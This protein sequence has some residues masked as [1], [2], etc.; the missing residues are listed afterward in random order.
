M[1]Y[2]GNAKGVGVPDEDRPLT[3]ETNM[4]ANSTSSSAL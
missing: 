1:L 4:A 2:R 3:C